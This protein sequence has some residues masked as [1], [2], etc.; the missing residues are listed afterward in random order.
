MIVLEVIRTVYPSGSA[1][2][3]WPTPMLPAAPGLFSM[4]KLAFSS[5][6]SSGCNK[7]VIT[8]TGPPGP[9]GTTIFTGRSG[10]AAY[11]RLTRKGEAPAKAAEM[12]RKRRRHKSGMRLFI[13]QTLLYGIKGENLREN[14]TS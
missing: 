7:R 5:S 8:S 4:K 11:A 10:Q 12:R 14:T 1:R 6:V 13:G 3:T 2:A 9:N